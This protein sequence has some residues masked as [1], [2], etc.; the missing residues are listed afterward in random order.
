MSTEPHAALLLPEI[1]LCLGKHLDRKD[2]LAC[3]VVCRLWHGHLIRLLW[4]DLVLP[5]KYHVMTSTTGHKASQF[6]PTDAFKER[7]DLVRSLVCNSLKHHLHYLVPNCNQLTALEIDD[8][9]EQTALPLLRLNKAS[10]GSVHL[11]RDRLDT[12]VR[13]PSAQLE[14][15]TALKDCANLDRLWL[16]NVQVDGWGSS[17]E[18]QEKRKLIGARRE[19]LLSLPSSVC[20]NQFYEIADRLTQLGI[21]KEV[22][23]TPPNPQD[24]FYRLWKLTLIE[25]SLTYKDQ[26]QLISQCQYLTHLRLQLTRRKRSYYSED[27]FLPYTYNTI[28][29]SLLEAENEGIHLARLE[30]CPITHLDISRSTLLDA[31]I[32]EL[33]VHFPRLIAFTAQGTHLG[34]KSIMVLCTGARS[35]ELQ[36]LDVTDTAGESAWIQDLLSSCSGL[37]V[38][39]ATSILARDVALGSKPKSSA[40]WSNTVFSHSSSTTPNCSFWTCLGL[41]EL[42]LS[43]IQVP[44][45]EVDVDE[46]LLIGMSRRMQMLVYDQLARLTQL[47]VLSLG[48]DST[49]TW[50]RTETLELSLASGLGK[51]ETLREL[52]ELNF[53]FMDHRLTM[54]EVEWMMAHWPRLRKVTGTIGAEVE[55][56]EDEGEVVSESRRTQRVDRHELYLQRQYPL[57]EFS[58]R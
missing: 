42:Y 27:N 20:S 4:H 32:A 17:E 2:F 22:I 58:T 54:A 6:P 8:L 21:V 43:I 23:R 30:V 53:R 55:I 3:L 12:K 7:G 1:I 44:T 5:Q 56:V 50:F 48:G 16:S 47:R 15:L 49:S 39:R 9:T 26:I 25:S 18:D 14:L 29:H 11:K 31:E 37:R 41:E 35:N 13:S 38:F 33:L 46:S 24:V 19:P 52:R 57:V 40:F 10:L 45:I 34:P 51:L 28:E 36:E